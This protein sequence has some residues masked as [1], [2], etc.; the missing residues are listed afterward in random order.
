MDPRAFLSNVPRM[1]VACRYTQGSRSFVWPL[2]CV[3][4]VTRVAFNPIE[5]SHS[6]LET[7]SFTDSLSSPPPRRMTTLSSFP[8][9]SVTTFPQRMLSRRIASLGLLA[10]LATGCARGRDDQRGADDLLE[11]GT[12]AQSGSNEQTDENLDDISDTQIGSDQSGETEDNGSQ[13]DD[14]TLPKFDLELPDV[15][16]NDGSDDMVCNVDL[17]FIID[18]SASMADYQTAI[19]LAFPNFAKSLRQS[20]PPE[21]NV[22][23]GVTSSEM[24]Y[25]SSGTT[26]Q[27]GSGCT[28]SGDND[29]DYTTFYV[30]PDQSMSG[31]NGA[32]GRLYRPNGLAPYFSIDMDASDK[33][34]EALEAWFRAAAAI[35]TGGSNIE[36]LTAPVG[37]VADPANAAAND[38]FLRDYGTVMVTFF[39]QDEPDQTPSTIDGQDGGVAMLNRLVAAKAGCGGLDCI[40]AGG[41]TD[42]DACGASRPITQYVA[43]LT[44]PASIAPLPTGGT[45]QE[46]AD[47]MNELL[48]TALLSVI[49]ETCSSIISPK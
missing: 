6:Y 8:I 18:N 42:L 15:I 2:S 48:T 30:T 29:A 3:G 5:T 38:G 25:S 17:L 47:K 16:P 24:G 43:G 35:G 44:R 22:H 4:I 23:V 21:A 37:W 46:I 32:Q 41:F 1:R 9:W 36:M 20:L 7:H 27:N 49:E 33:E 12:A 28:F 40:V 31:R 11:S 10:T 45:P 19:G 14:A 34:F 26:T 39:M 13:G